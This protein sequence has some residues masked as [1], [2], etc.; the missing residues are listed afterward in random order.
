MI[1]TTKTMTPEVYEN[2]RNELIALLGEVIKDAPAIEGKTRDELDATID[3]LKRNSFEIVLVGEFQ[4][5]KSTTFNAMCGREISPMGIGIKTSACKISAQAIA[6]DQEEYVE[7]RWKTD[8]E[9]TETIWGLLVAHFE[10]DPEALKLFKDAEGDLLHC[11]RDS[12]RLEALK[13]FKDAEGSPL[14]PS[15]TDPTVFRLAKKVLALEWKKYEQHKAAYSL[16]RLEILKIAT[17]LVRYCCSKEL[18]ELRKHRRIS[19]EALK[20]LVAFPLDWESRWAVGAG[21]TEWAFDEIIFAFLGEAQCYIHCDNLERL[22]CVITDCPGLF[23]GPWDS[24]VAQEAMMGADAILYL[25]R[26]DKAT[27]EAE[28]K[29]L[30]HIHNGQQEHKLFFTMNAKGCS[31]TFPTT[32]VGNTSVRRE[33]ATAIKACGI[34]IKSEEDLPVFNP[35]LAFASRCKLSNEQKLGKV[36]TM[37]LDVNVFDSEQMDNIHRLLSDRDALYHA[38]DFPS[39]LDRVEAFIIS[40]KARSIL[41]THG[42]DKIVAALDALQANLM[43]KEKL[44]AEAKETVEREVQIRRERLN[45]FRQTALS[46]VT[47]LVAD[48]QKRNALGE[49]FFKQAYIDKAETYAVQIVDAVEEHF[50]SAVSLFKTLL[51][52]M[53]ESISIAKG[54]RKVFIRDGVASSLTWLE[55]VAQEAIRGTVTEVIDGWL[56]NVQDGRNKVFNDTYGGATSK[57]KDFLKKQWQEELKEDSMNFL[58]QLS[59]SFDW[60]NIEMPE[61]TIATAKNESLIRKIKN[62]IVLKVV[63]AVVALAV[64]IALPIVVTVVLVIINTAGAPLVI[65]WLLSLL[66]GDAVTGY[67]LKAIDD[68]LGRKLVANLREGLPREIRVGFYDQKDSILDQVNKTLIEQMLQTFIESCSDELERQTR[69]FE[70]LVEEALTQK[71]LAQEKQWQI[72]KEANEVRVSQ[73]EPVQARVKVFHEGLEEYFKV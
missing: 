13:L 18:K 43:R 63:S 70:C 55:S 24:K 57:L 47:N 3:R 65:A 8:E 38:S 45:N 19:V 29:V 51:T 49:D 35:F 48:K 73:I 6:A 61:V 7:L 56:K 66:V 5:G 42:S 4:G 2:K 34:E 27:G 37:Y 58:G 31:K 16:E 52:I 53:K 64:M 60:D 26:G 11:D 71:T 41:V 72:A 21:R 46:G 9:L 28:L 39:I 25:L 59:F 69:K 33:V 12:S 10:D 1:E 22:G 23:A 44:A 62:A 36:L 15:L 68:H 50:K 30:K 14:F 67:A 32:L 54:E 40:H 20:S 17:P